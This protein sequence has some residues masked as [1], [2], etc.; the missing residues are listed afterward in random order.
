[1]GNRWA[2]RGKK[3][4]RMVE[5]AL[6]TAGSR[7][8][9]AVIDGEARPWM[10]ALSHAIGAGAAMDKH[11]IAD[12]E[13]ANAR[14]SELAEQV[15][16]LLNRVLDAADAEQRVATTVAPPASPTFQLIAAEWNQFVEENSK[17]PELLGLTQE[18][19][20]MLSMAEQSTL[21][22]AC[23]SCGVR[24]LVDGQDVTTMNPLL[25]R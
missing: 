10:P 12:R 19:W 20:N 1:M 11:R 21:R 8:V 2:T 25:T 3:P 7:F 17:N 5:A 18:D 13:R 6:I 23:E 4:D 24:L 14:N 9:K 15:A 22:D 16:G